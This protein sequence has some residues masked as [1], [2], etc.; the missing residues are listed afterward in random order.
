[1]T[2]SARV[3]QQIIEAEM[4]KLY[5]GAK[6]TV[7]ACEHDPEWFLVRAAWPSKEFPYISRILT[8]YATLNDKKRMEAAQWVCG[9]VVLDT[10]PASEACPHCGASPQSDRLTVTTYSHSKTQ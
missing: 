3:Q 10:K 9:D 1:M 8:T 6:V 7:E 4:R 2:V 5:T